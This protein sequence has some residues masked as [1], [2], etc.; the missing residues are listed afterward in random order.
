VPQFLLKS[1]LFPFSIY[2]TLHKRFGELFAKSELMQM[3]CGVP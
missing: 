2:N 3:L 1:C